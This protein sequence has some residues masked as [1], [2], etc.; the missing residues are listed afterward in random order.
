MLGVG[1]DRLELETEGG[2]VATMSWRCET[3]TESVQTMDSDGEIDDLAN[4]AASQNV[5]RIVTLLNHIRV[6]VCLMGHFVIYCFPRPQVLRVGV[7]GR[8]MDSLPALQNAIKRDPESYKEE[9]RQ[10]FQHY[11]A[12]LGIFRLQPNRSAK[13]AT[14][15]SELVVFLSHVRTKRLEIICHDKQSNEH[16]CLFVGSSR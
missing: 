9:F 16:V 5:S 8:L 11:T 13:Q 4:T 7:R 12:N 14:L 15:F 3:K 2:R 1:P 10:Q 6:A